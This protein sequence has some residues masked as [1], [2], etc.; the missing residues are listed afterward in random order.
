MIPIELAGARER[1]PTVARSRVRGIGRGISCLLNGTASINRT[2]DFNDD[3]GRNPIKV[4]KGETG[5]HLRWQNEPT[6]RK[7]ERERDGERAKRNVSRQL[8]DRTKPEKCAVIAEDTM[9]VGRRLL[10]R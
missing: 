8:S 10:P 4:I 1:V 2:V 6:K 9:H 3:S 7:R 5:E